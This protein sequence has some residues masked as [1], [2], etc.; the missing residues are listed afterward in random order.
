MIYYYEKIHE[1]NFLR[2]NESQYK[3]RERFLFETL[4]LVNK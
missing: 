2:K 1:T 4:K 3:K